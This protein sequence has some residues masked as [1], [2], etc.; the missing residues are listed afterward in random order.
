LR[1]KFAQPL[2][3]QLGVLVIIGLEHGTLRV[4]IADVIEL[5]RARA[6]D[7]IDRFATTIACGEHGNTVS[8]VAVLWLI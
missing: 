3:D 8:S 5:F 7:A 1:V 6:A 4:E 2:E